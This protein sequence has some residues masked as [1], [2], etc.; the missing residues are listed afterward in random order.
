MKK[1]ITLL[2]VF[3]LLFVFLSCSK[4]KIH[5]EGEYYIVD[6][7]TNEI[8]AI[9]GDGENNEVYVKD[10]GDLVCFNAYH[11]EYVDYYCFENAK[12]IDIDDW[13]D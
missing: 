1:I 11:N 12:V 9:I 10:F 5:D 2:L 6:K 8:L 3:I 7:E 4:P 13:E